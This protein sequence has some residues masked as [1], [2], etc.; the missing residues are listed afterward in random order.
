MKLIPEG[1]HGERQVIL[2][3]VE[4]EEPVVGKFLDAFGVVTSCKYSV[5]LILNLRYIR[6]I[7]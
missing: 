5:N 1:L 7:L 6:R 4:D 2:E 3:W